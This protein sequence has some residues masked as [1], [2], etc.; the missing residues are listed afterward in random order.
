[1]G[2]MTGEVR[3]EVVRY[4]DGTVL[5][6][7][8]GGLIGACAYGVDARLDW[9]DGGRATLTA[10]TT[11]PVEQIGLDVTL[12]L[13]GWGGGYVLVPGAVYGGNHFRVIPAEY[14][15]IYP[16]AEPEAN[17]PAI[18]DLPRLPEFH[19]LAS[20]A[21]FPAIAAWDPQAAGLWAILFPQASAWGQTG[22]HVAE[23]VD[24][25]IMRVQF[26]GVRTS[27]RYAMVHRDRPCPDRG[28]SLPSGSELNADLL[29]I[30]QRG[31]SLTQL[32]ELLDEHRNA[33]LP[34][35]EPQTVRSLSR[36]A[37]LVR[38][39]QMT[40]AWN[41]ASG[42]FETAD[43]DHGLRFQLGWVGGGMTTLP[44][45][46]SAEPQAAERAARNLDV[47][48]STMQSSSG[49]FHGAWH[50]GRLVGDGF[51]HEHAESWTMVRKN[52]DWLLYLMRQVL[53]APDAPSAWSE[54]AIRLAEAFERLWCRHGQWGQFVD[55]HSGR[56]VVGGSACGG[57]ALAGMALAS[58]RFARP[59]WLGVAL[60]AARAYG[61]D[62]ID[63][64]LLVGGP[65]EILKAPDSES[66][67]GMVEG[68]V[69]LWEAARHEWLLDIAQKAAYQ[70]ATWVVPYDFPFPHESCFGRMGMG[71]TGTVV[72]N[73]QN[74]HSA[75]G[76]CTGSTLPL[77]K[78]FRAT[79]R[80]RWLDLACRITRA[81]PQFVSSAERP[82][83]AHDGS[84]LPPGFVNER[85]NLSDWE[86]PTMGPGEV[87]CGATWAGTSVLLSALEMPGVYVQPRTGI[88]AAADAV[89][90]ELEGA[91]L[92]VRNLTDSPADVRVLVDHQPSEPLGELS[93]RR[94]RIVRL[95]P[96]GEARLSLPA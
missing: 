60:A 92:L 89:E 34:E 52:G 46:E 29:V 8:T 6:R 96:L 17:D 68:L 11:E 73:V 27:G 87:Y 4:L 36:A 44:L 40:R 81:L 71:S 39:D 26:P 33:I 7:S 90:A 66:A 43:S 16:S 14:P 78:L 32:F 69:T 12:E 13:R 20:D 67:F 51:G 53:A 82:I 23:G 94:H 10:R 1:M 57:T 93:W 35:G 83:L 61:T 64:G 54:A 25:L 50:H 72:A 22:I 79:G 3:V 5:G 30:R 55:V 18:T 88:V 77:L 37:E 63:L 47:V 70:A 19:L 24:G 48:C 15:P 31:E 65:G 2:V 86:S 41:E 21:S 85:V 38:G 84:P 9:A 56:M 74:K 62:A 75:P 80:R 28:A 45:L 91:E 49:W 59:E 42:V 58:Q 95:K 76:I